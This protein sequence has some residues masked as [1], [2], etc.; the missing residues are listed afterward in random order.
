[1]DALA[2]MACG[3]SVLLVIAAII[4]LVALSS[5][6]LFLLKLGVIAGYWFKQEPPAQ[7]SDYSLEQSRPVDK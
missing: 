2:G 4:A 1:M 6:A 5:L 7:E 3:G